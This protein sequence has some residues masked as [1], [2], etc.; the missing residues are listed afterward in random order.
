MIHIVSLRCE[1][2]PDAATKQTKL[3]LEFG[4]TTTTSTTKEGELKIQ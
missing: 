1:G 2:Q 3:N 4:Y